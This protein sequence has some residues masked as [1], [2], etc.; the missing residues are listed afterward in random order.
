[1]HCVF[2]TK[3]RKPTITE[4]MREK[5]W[6]YIFGIAQNHKIELLAIGGVADHVHLLVC[7]PP[8]MLVFGGLR[9][10]SC[11]LDSRMIARDTC[12]SRQKLEAPQVPRLGPRLR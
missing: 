7:V 1:M 4:D 3:D 11:G 6:A 2:S 8:K 12:S 10:A 9:I 5:L